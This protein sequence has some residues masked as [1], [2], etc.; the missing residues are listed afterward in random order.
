MIRAG[1][2][3]FTLIE[4]LMVLAITALILTLL[5]QGMRLG[6]RG[7][8]SFRRGVQTQQDMIPVEQ[9]L[10]RLFEHA[11]PGVYPNPPLFVATPSSVT[12]T[13]AL[14]DPATGSVRNADIRLEVSGKRLVLWWTPHARGIPFGAQPRPDQT[15]LLESVLR[16]DIAYA[17]KAAPAGWRSVWT[18]AHLPLL[19]RVTL[20]PA[21]GGP[22]WPPMV[23]R[24]PREP[25]EE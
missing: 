4:V 14:P 9:A 24:L 23:M 12:F 10:R 21:P 2:R 15:V 19:V 5:G 25:A 20:T 6:M 11:D 3:G 17:G 7:T 13:T 18:D 8:D 16:M 22:S 1:Q